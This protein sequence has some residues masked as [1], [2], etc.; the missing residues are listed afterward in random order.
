M[1]INKNQPSRKQHKRTKR[2]RLQ[3]QIAS[4]KAKQQKGT[5]NNFKN[6]DL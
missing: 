1:N 2:K 6:N 3:K 5:M 4:E